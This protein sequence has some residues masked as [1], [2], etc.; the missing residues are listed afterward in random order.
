MREPLRRRDVPLPDPPEDPPHDRHRGA[1]LGAAGLA[2]LLLV[3]AAVLFLRSRPA[4]VVISARPTPPAGPSPEATTTAAAD[5]TVHVAGAVRRPGIVVV[6]A[7][8]RVAD[9]LAAAGGYTDDAAP[10]SL[11]LARRVSDGE[12]LHVPRRG[13]P[14]AAEA[15][16]EGGGGGPGPV[17]LNTATEKELEELPGIGPAL[18][19][20]IV[21]YRRAH[22]GFRDV[23][24]LLDVPGI[25][26]KLFSRLRDKVTVGG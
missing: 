4:P 10:D 22:N 3:V 1:A 25:G 23:R 26:E 14:V 24:Q 18:A 13:E 15:P 19:K 2:V 17:D 11:N 5:V 7:R 12:R 9:A 6:P 20:Q 16:G 8:S 21:D